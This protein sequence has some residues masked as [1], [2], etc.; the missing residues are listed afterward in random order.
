MDLGLGRRDE[1]AAY[2]QPVGEIAGV[3]ELGPSAQKGELSDVL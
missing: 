2:W 3:Q 1:Q